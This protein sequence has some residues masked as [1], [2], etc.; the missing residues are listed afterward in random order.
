MLAFGGNIQ[1]IM[2]PTSSKV[3]MSSSFQCWTGSMTKRGKQVWQSKEFF[4]HTLCRKV[5]KGLMKYQSDII[6][7]VHPLMQHVMDLC[8]CHP[9]WY[10]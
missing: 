9:T 3:L 4:S 2:L 7:S 5:A 10:I 1:K 8:T 6:I